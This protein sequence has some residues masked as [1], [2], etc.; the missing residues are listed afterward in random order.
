MAKL[1]ISDLPRW[2]AGMENPGEATTERRFLCFAHGRDSAWEAI[3]LDLDLAV[4]G[5]SFDEVKELL[6]ESISTY[7]EDALKEDERTPHAF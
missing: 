3:C 2:C 7:L 6:S 5:S 4:Q 1:A